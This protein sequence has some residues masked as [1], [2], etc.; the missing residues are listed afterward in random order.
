LRDALASRFF[1]PFVKRR[2][3][4]TTLKIPVPVSVPRLIFLLFGCSFEKQQPSL[5]EGQY[6][7][8]LL[9]YQV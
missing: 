7:M 8:Y 5:F 6:Y 2:K 4:V 9:F 3:E 1:L